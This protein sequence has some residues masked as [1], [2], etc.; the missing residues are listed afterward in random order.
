MKGIFIV[1]TDTEVGKT[2]VSCAISS[3]LKK[4]GFEFGVLKPFAS[5]SREDAVLLG[6]SAGV[7]TDVNLINPV[8]LRYPLAPSCSARL[9]GKKVNIKVALGALGRLKKAYPFVIVEGIGGVMVPL[10]SRYLLADFIKKTGLPAVIVARSGLGTINHT[11]LTH[12][13]LRKRGIK[14]L[15]VIY[16]MFRGKKLDE[17]VSFREIEKITGLKTLGKLRVNGKFTKRELGWVIK[18]LKG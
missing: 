16:N 17:K 3:C 5:G 10:T 4:A 13:A 18:G 6:R 8:F 11:L 14:V 2:Y 15:G 7:N 12:E 1:G 9:E